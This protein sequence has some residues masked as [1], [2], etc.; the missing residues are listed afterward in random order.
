MSFSGGKTE[1]PSSAPRIGNLKSADVSSNEQGIPVPWCAGADF[2]P[3]TW[4]V[5][6]AYNR[7]EKPVKVK[8]GKKKV[9]AGYDIYADVAGIACL[10]LIDSI[11]AIESAETIIW[12]GDK[13]RQDNPNHSEYWRAHITT[14]VGDFYVYW[15]RPD[16]PVDDILLGPIGRQN[17]A[18][19][20]PAY[21]GQ[22]LVVCKKYYFGQ[23]SRT[24]PSTRIRV[25]RAP[26]PEIG[27]FPPRM[28]A[29]QG[30]SIV[31][32]A[33]ELLTNPVFGAGIPASH[34]IPGEWE[35]L[36]AAVIA[37]HGCHSPNSDRAAPVADFVS[38]LF[39][40]FDGYAR[41]ENGKIRPG[42]F[43]HTG[44]APGIVATIDDHALAAPLALTITAPG[45]NGNEVRV[46]YR[47]G[48]DNL[49]E[50]SIAA[51]ASASV[52]ARQSHDPQ[53]LETPGIIQTAQAAAYAQRAAI[54]A[55]ES[56]VSG[57]VELRA[58][59]RADGT[60]IAPG[61][62]VMLES[63]IS[64][65]RRV[66]RVAG[67]NDAWAG[68]ITLDLTAERGF[69][70]S[71]PAF[72]PDTRPNLGQV[73]PLAVDAASVFELPSAL[74]LDESGKPVAGIAVAVLARRPLSVNANDPSIT[75]EAVQGFQLWCAAAGTTT[76]DPL[77]WQTTW[78]VR[79]TLTAAIAAGGDTLQ[80]AIDPENIDDDRI[81]SHGVSAQTDNT[82][83]VVIGGEILSAGEITKAPGNGLAWEIGVL[84]GRLE[85]DAAAHPAGAVV[86]LVYRDEVTAQT[87]GAWTP[88]A[89]WHFKLETR[90]AEEALDLEKA[91]VLAHTF[92]AVPPS[93]PVDIAVSLL[94]AS[95]AVG[96]FASVAGSMQAPKGDIASYKVSLIK[97]REDDAEESRREMVSDVCV[98][99]RKSGG[100]ISVVTLLTEAGRYRAEV[101]TVS[102]D[103]RVTIGLSAIVQAGV[104]Q[105]SG[106]PNAIF[107]F[108]PVFFCGNKYLQSD[109]RVSGRC[110]ILNGVVSISL[111][112]TIIMAATVLPGYDS[113]AS[114]A[115]EIT[116]DQLP[117]IYWP[118]LDPAMYYSSGDY[119]VPYVITPCLVGN[120]SDFSDVA[121]S[122]AVMEIRPASG[123][124]SR[125]TL[126]FSPV[127][128][129]GNNV[130]GVRASHLGTSVS[131]SPSNI[132]I[133]ITYPLGIRAT[134]QIYRAIV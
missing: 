94:P 90:T 65:V 130:R 44:Q 76:Y 74:A 17:P 127:R 119:L 97:L 73:L 101:R 107:E 8:A 71:L 1:V 108:V 40:Y 115:F 41:I 36:S 75:S 38:D 120:L 61:D 7:I 28:N 80:L 18:L 53:E 81:V 84:R 78:A 83:L 79:A 43:P 95:V 50:K 39:L 11:T 91:P 25:H 69:F 100:P 57:T 49:S 21:R 126:C 26:R 89:T 129:S 5:P 67:R 131:G 113:T 16:Q 110:V 109:L 122:C 4:V 86:W 42:A 58:A 27:N 33:L 64:G 93:G 6:A 46:K 22:V 112:M 19:E 68:A 2:R 118:E 92:A 125:T 48:G 32:G 14:D 85:T 116:E 123:G 82:L 31:A 3:L 9:T 34:F 70:Q 56:E 72:V 54:V 99:E 10:G 66:M 96:D 134:R 20:H 102:D 29:E 88:E 106:P 30:E 55:A 24:V 59:D 62:C 15:G 121:V 47:D 13:R 23:D 128:E 117:A 52:E 124:A 51:S 104:P 132:R 111:H 45:R 133:N 12:T 114:I 103:G 35:G 87:S 98:G 105:P 37:A 77:S 60:R 63:A